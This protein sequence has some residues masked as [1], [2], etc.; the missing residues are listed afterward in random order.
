VFG[1]EEMSGARMEPYFVP[2]LLNIE[3]MMAD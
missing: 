3:M 2:E 1:G